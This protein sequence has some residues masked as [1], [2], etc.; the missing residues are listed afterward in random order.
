MSQYRKLDPAKVVA[1][2][3]LLSRRVRERFPDLGI[4]KLAAEVHAIAVENAERTRLVRQPI[5]W[6]RILAVVVVVG[7][8]S[9]V[10]IAELQTVGPDLGGIASITD[11]VTTL[12]ASL[13]AIVF[14]GAAIFFVMSLET[15]AK[16]SRTLA[17]MTELRS[18]AHIID[19][20]QLP[21]GPER[22]LGGATKT[23]SSPKVDLTPFQMER[24]LDYCSEMLS[25]V[26]KIAAAYV[27]EFH[28]PGAVAAVDE[29]ET[30]TTGISGKIWQKIT[31]LQRTTAD[32]GFD[33]AVPATGEAA[34]P[35]EGA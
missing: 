13:G 3:E 17:A 1:T 26:G 18:L 25:L 12:E 6:L 21:K 15:R 24:Y 31:I 16:R 33:T 8:P 34:S 14:L 19:M 27:Q 29:I 4:A 35:G 32:L 11:F 5:L 30:L 10:L 28:D 20:H 22:V 2:A 9:A 23:A 7:I